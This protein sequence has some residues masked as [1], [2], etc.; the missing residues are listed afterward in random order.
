[1]SPSVDNG[2]YEHHDRGWNDWEWSRDREREHSQDR[3]HNHDESE[4]WV[5][6]PLSPRCKPEPEVYYSQH[7]RN[8]SRNED[9]IKIDAD[10]TISDSELTGRREQL[11]RMTRES[12]P[13]TSPRDSPRRL[14][15]DER[16]QQEHGLD[17]EEE[18]QKRL[19]QQ[20]QQQ[21]PARHLYN[22]GYQAHP[23]QVCFNVEFVMSNLSLNLHSYL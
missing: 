20:Q 3:E 1:M 13:S 15:L 17:V 4:R 2:D 19:Q 16:L 7:T 22:W 18:R 8:I 10:S 21:Q 14:S 11:G 5:G 9:T 6:R 12:S 23:V